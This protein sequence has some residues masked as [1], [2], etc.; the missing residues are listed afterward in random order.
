M[1]TVDITFARLRK[2]KTLY[3]ALLVILCINV[4]IFYIAPQSL[5]VLC[6]LKRLKF[7][8]NFTEGF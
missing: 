5:T 7:D 1:K 3:L 8:F 2:K 6:I 4:N